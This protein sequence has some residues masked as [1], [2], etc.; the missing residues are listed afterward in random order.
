MERLQW[1]ATLSVGVSLIDNEHRLICALINDLSK[2]TDICHGVQ[3]QLVEEHLKTLLDSIHQHFVS[4]ERMLEE[5]GY[6][7]LVTHKQVHGELEAKLVQF[8]KQ[9]V[10]VVDKELIDF[11]HRWFLDH[12]QQVDM[13]YADYLKTH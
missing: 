4:E 2:M 9:G 1:D 11:L 13:L 8:R 12:V 10:F 6:P 3:V 5:Q 7:D